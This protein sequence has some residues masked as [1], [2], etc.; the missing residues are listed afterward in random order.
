MGVCFVL[1]CFLIHERIIA[2]QQLN[3]YITVPHIWAMDLIRHKNILK[4]I[5]MKVSDK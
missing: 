5:N 4:Y 3:I 2:L 1:F